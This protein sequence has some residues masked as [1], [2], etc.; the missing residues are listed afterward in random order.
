MEGWLLGP[1][2]PPGAA[3]HG[4]VPTGTGRE[5]SGFGTMNL[6]GADRRACDATGPDPRAVVP[7]SA[8]RAAAPVS[9]AAAMIAGGTVDRCP[10]KLDQIKLLDR[11]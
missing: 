10:W 8:G 6:T 1:A 7:A 9:S 3:A 11:A 2:G 5:H 4:P